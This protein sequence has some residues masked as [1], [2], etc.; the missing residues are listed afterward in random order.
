MI[1]ARAM[2][3]A[4][5]LG[6]TLAA[7]GRLTI[8]IFHRV[9]ARPDP[10]FPELWHA[11]LFEDRLRWLASVFTVLPLAEAVDRLRAGRLPPRAAAITFDDG[12]R[13]NIEVA[14]PI[15]QRLGLT[16][17]FFVADG[18]LD[19][20]RMFNDSVYEALRRLPAGEIEL[21]VPERTRVVIDSMASRRAAAD[22]I[23]PTLKYRPLAEREGVCQQ[24]A[25]LA[26]S[27]LPTDLMMSSSQVAQLVEQGMEVGG[28]TVNH[29]ILAALETAAAEREIT[30]N[31]ARLEAIVGRPLKLFAYPNGGPGRDYTCAHVAMVRQAGYAAAVSTSVGVATAATD[32]YQLPRFTP[33]DLRPGRFEAGFVRNT[34]NRVATA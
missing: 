21:P 34:M 5:R 4:T 9:P 20:G 14:A 7:R 30:A 6:L 32:P 23:L 17:T 8:L 11:D 29:P 27:P 26:T 13:D 24:L 18:Y 15:L 16:A 3:A 22:R 31:Q 10:L 28:H 25:A 12:Y 19:G 1:A 33:W 2:R